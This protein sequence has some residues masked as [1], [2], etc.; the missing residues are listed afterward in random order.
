MEYSRFLLRRKGYGKGVRQAL[1]IMAAICG[2]L[3]R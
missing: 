1:Q 2:S 3:L